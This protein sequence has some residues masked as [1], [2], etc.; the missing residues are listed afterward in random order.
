MLLAIDAGNTNI[1]FAACEGETVR[2]QWRAVTAT[3]SHRRRICREAGAAAGAGRPVASPI[4]MPPSSPRWCRRRCSTC[5]SSAANISKPS[6]W[7]S[8]IRRSISA[9]RTTCRPARS[10]G[11]RPP[12]NT[13]AA[14]DRYPGRP[15]RGGFRHRHQFRRRQPEAAIMK[16]ASSRRAPTC[17]AEALHQAAAL[18]PRVAI[19]RTQNVIGRDTVRPCSP[20]SIGAMSA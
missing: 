17:P 18:L 20:A 9:S 13:V 19:H 12:V 1:V 8:A 3:L 6:R 16:A 11:R 15:D 4:S 5:A 14:H 7:G 2:A 10:R